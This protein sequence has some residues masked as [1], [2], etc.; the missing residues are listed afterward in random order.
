MCR[1][2][3]HMMGFSSSYPKIWRNTGSLGKA[4]TWKL[5]MHLI[6]GDLLWW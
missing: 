4:P 2:T 5:K 6:S 3:I 1:N